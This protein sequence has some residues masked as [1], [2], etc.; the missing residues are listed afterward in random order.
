M[1]CLF[2]RDDDNWRSMFHTLG[3]YYHALTVVI[4]GWQL[5]KHGSFLR[6]ISLC[7]DRSHETM[8]TY[9]AWFILEGFITMLWWR[10]FNTLGI[11]HH[12]LTVVIRRW[13]MTEHESNLRELLSCFDRC[14]ETMTTEGACFIDESYIIMLC[15]MSWD[16]DNWRNMIHTFGI[17]YH[18]LTV[19]MGR[20]QLM[21]H[22][23][24]LRDY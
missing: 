3:I 5:T 13:Q 20:W 19:V 14:D 11:F 16:D 2:A 18:P 23:S 22:V 24:Y 17:Y 4:R 21:E 8:T 1:L 6:D 9:K 12:A 15:P 7:F 10:M